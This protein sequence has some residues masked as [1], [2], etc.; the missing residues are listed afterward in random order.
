MRRYII[1]LLVTTTSLLHIQLHRLHLVEA[2]VKIEALLPPAL[3]SGES[4]SLCPV[5]RVSEARPGSQ[6]WMLHTADTVDTAGMR[7]NTVIRCT[8]GYAD[9]NSK[10]ELEKMRISSL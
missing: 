5:M 4:R 3:W 1:V 6:P 2:H 9:A 10:M 8:H 7:R